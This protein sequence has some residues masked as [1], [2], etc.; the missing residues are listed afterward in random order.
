MCLEAR[1]HSMLVLPQTCGGKSTHVFAASWILAEDFEPSLIWWENWR[2]ILHRRILTPYK[3]FGK[4]HS[5]YE[6]NF[7]TVL[8]GRLQYNI[9][10]KFY[11]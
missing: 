6:A 2:K 5:Y 9:P 8:E 1:L 11:H 4:L 10:F 3:V 7:L